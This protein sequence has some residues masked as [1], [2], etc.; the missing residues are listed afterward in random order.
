[1]TSDDGGAVAS[2]SIEPLSWLRRG[3]EAVTVALFFSYCVIVLLQVFFRYVLNDSVVWSEETVRFEQFWVIMLATSLCAYRK[4][5]IRL[6]GIEAM[7]P[8]SLRRSLDLIGD[9][10]TIAC[11][12]FLAWYG[13]ELALRSTGMKSPAMQITMALP[14]AAVPVGSVLTILWTVLGWYRGQER[15]GR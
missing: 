14:Y 3:I 12:L 15:G 9:G 7:L 6:E 5:H 13:A 8:G 11:C 10:V 1:M 2:R 4:S